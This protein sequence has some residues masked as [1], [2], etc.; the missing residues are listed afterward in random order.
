MIKNFWKILRVGALLERVAIDVLGPLPI[1][2]RGNKYILILGDYFTKWI[3]ANRLENQK[4]ETVAEVIVTQ[5]ISR[6]GVPLQIHSDQG[7]NFEAAVF[8]EICRLLGIEKTRTT[9]LYPQS[10]GMVERFNRTLENKLAIF[11]DRNQDDWDKWIPFVLMAYRSSVHESTRQTPAC[12]IF[13][14][15]LN[16]PLDLLY[17]RPPEPERPEKMDNYVQELQEKLKDIHKFP[18]ARMQIAS[19]RMKQRYDV[20][21]SRKIFESE[22]LVWLHNPQRKKGISPK[23]DWEGP[24]K[25]VK[26]I[27]ELLHRVKRSSGSK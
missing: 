11:V 16:L 20:G 26:R 1:S 7:R 6:F 15:E 27:N 8:Q 17:G 5:F 25:V 12:L 21:T 13:G 18:R 22:D 4:A 3:E 19:E 10:N 14:R 24:Y 9:A 2:A 23:L